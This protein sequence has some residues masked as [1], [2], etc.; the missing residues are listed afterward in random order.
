MNSREI[1]ASAKDMPTSEIS[2]LVDGL[3]QI[4]ANNQR[5]EQLA[6]EL[7]ALAKKNGFSM[8]ALGFARAGAEAPV[9]RKSRVLNAENQTYVVEGADLSL[10]PARRRA[11]LQAAGKLVSYSQLS[12]AQKAKANALIESINSR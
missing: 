11:D 7:E 8:S 6:G 10:A 2:K 4:I 5:K 3:N 12:A 1:L 9:S